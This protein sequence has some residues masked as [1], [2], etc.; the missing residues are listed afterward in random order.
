MFSSAVSLA[1]RMRCFGCGEPG[2]WLCSSCRDALEPPVGLQAIPG[3]DR[4]HIPWAYAGAARDLVLALKLRAARPAAEVMAA[5]VAEEIQGS[6]TLAEA[7]TWVPGRSRDIRVRGFDHAEAIAR[8]LGARIGMPVVGLLER[9]RDR[10]DQTTLSG[11]ARWSN[12]DGAFAGIGSAARVLVV[13]DLVTTGATGASCA[14]A[15]RL[16]GASH[17]EVAAP[18]RA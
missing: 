11:H 4:A 7:I 3:V 6:G 18:C 10:P 12:L 17:V 9:T 14:G 2:R 5:A 8:E 15:L 16:L 1:A 13:D